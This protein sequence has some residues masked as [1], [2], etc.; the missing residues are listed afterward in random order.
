MKK[1]SL[2]ILTFFLGSLSS[3]A[4]TVGTTALETAQLARQVAR[5]AERNALY[6]PWL[7]SVGGLY[8]FQV[9]PILNERARRS[10]QQVCRL[11]NECIETFTLP[12]GAPV[13]SVLPF[14]RRALKQ[15]YP[16]TPFLKNSKQRADYSVARNNRLLMRELHRFQ[17]VV[18]PEFEKN[19]P[20]LQQQADQLVQPKDPLDFV[21]RQITA[22]TKWLFIG[23][24][25]E[26]PEIQ[27]AV[28][29]FLLNVRE[30]QPEREII[31]LTE[32]LPENYEWQLNEFIR[33]PGE[34]KG[35]DPER[36]VPPSFQQD[37]RAMWN[38]FVRYGIRVIGLEPQKNLR[39]YMQMR[40]Y[41]VY[42]GQTMTAPFGTSMEGM[43]QRNS[44]WKKTMEDYRTLH[45]DALIVVY[46]GSAHSLYYAPFSVSG[47][48]NPAESFVFILHPD[49]RII[50]D[51]NNFLQV[52]SD[53]GT[54]EDL[55]G[56]QMSFPQPL[57][58]WSDPHLAQVA[59]FNAHFKVPV[60]FS[61]EIE[62]KLAKQKT[63]TDKEQATKQE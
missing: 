49:K 41:N 20:L 12:F 45:P 16:Q 38:E 53:T 54:L 63:F 57:L 29:T 48:K 33:L 55:T 8:S 17:N 59:G 14:Q 43:L 13:L 11:Q 19:L 7:P 3:T 2:L 37:Y 15:L 4:Q 6:I 34:D 35:Y 23:E 32:F 28:K 46:T 36:P 56:Y 47:G 10:I 21:A 51:E 1:Y 39:N 31:V 5:A 44:D 62:Q 24:H 26:I 27:T 30:R 50:K 9:T 52:S 42:M 18:W 61:K 58:Y 25:H 40:M 22:Q 60:T